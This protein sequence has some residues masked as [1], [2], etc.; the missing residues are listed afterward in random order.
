MLQ[1]LNCTNKHCNSKNTI[2]NLRRTCTN[3]WTQLS[4]AWLSWSSCFLELNLVF[5]QSKSCHVAIFFLSYMPF[6]SNCHANLR[7]DVIVSK[8]A[9]LLNII[10]SYSFLFWH[11]FHTMTNLLMIDKARSSGRV[12]RGT[13]RYSMAVVQAISILHFKIIYRTEMPLA[14]KQNSEFPT[15]GES[16]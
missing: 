15:L 7:W 3:N 9:I 12:L 10:S 2:C 5:L 11:P 8:L 16:T 1:S 6:Y 14:P 4:P 13:Y